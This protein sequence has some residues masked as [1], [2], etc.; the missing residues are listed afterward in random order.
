MSM[1]NSGNGPCRSDA[2]VSR[3]AG[4]CVECR[5]KGEDR[6]DMLLWDRS[7]IGGH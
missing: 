4:V 2:P 5:D 1:R 6:P 7:G 3:P